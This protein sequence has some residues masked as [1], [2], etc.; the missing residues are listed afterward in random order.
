MYRAIDERWTQS[1]DIGVGT[2][3][4]VHILRALAQ[5]SGKRHWEHDIET[6]AEQSGVFYISDGLE[7]LDWLEQLDAT[8]F[9]QENA[10]YIGV[11]LSEEDEAE[12]RTEV[13]LI[14]NEVYELQQCVDEWRLFVEKATETYLAIRFDYY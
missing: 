9:A 4:F 10:D 5:A 6:S 11:E 2:D 1:R 13:D 12:D 3:E 14:W 8:K 7:F